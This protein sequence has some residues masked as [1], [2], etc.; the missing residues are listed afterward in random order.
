MYG[1][2]AANQGQIFETANMAALWKLPMVF[3]CENNQ[4][5]MGTS[6]ERGSADGNFY[7]RGD[8]VPGIWADGMDV[9]AV[10]QVSGFVFVCFL[11][12]FFCVCVWF[13]ICCLVSLCRRLNIL[14]VQQVSGLHFVAF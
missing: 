9:L 7:T 5:G 4:F 2:G 14:A 6:T 3:L 12:V 13:S 11:L 1:D 8:Y 10:Q